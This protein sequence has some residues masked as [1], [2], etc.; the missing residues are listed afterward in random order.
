VGTALTSTD[1]FT[2]TLT[3]GT[4]M[5]GGT[6]TNTSFTVG[7]D[8]IHSPGN[9]PGTQTVDG[10]TETWASLGTYHWEIYDAEGDAGTDWD[11]IA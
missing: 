8:V 9:S 7:E 5:G 2:L 10:G 3:S 4:L 6:L 1:P 11:L